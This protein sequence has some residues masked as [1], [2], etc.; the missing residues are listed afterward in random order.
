M[1]TTMK[2]NGNVQVICTMP[3]R[4]VPK[5]GVN[6]VTEALR[7]NK[8]LDNSGIKYH[9]REWKKTGKLSKMMDCKQVD[10]FDEGTHPEYPKRKSNGP[11][12]MKRG[13]ARAWCQ[14]GA[15]IQYD[16]WNF[17]RKVV[18]QNKILGTVSRADVQSLM[19]DGVVRP[20]FDQHG[21]IKYCK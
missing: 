11:R 5:R 7:D 21:H 10:K 3:S 18:Y 2:Q 1:E 9:K 13:E 16:P 20:M 4:Y 12:A 17:V 8:R 6:Q 19:K 15:E 14:A